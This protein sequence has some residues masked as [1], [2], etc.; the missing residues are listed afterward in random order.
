MQRGF[1]RELLVERDVFAYARGYSG[2]S[3]VAVIN[4]GPER[5]IALR[6]V[7]LPD[8]EYL[9]VLGVLS[10]PVRVVKGAI[11]R[12]RVPACSA[13]LLEHSLPMPAG[14]SLVV[15]RLNGYT[16]RYDDRVVVVGDAPELGAWNPEK[17]TRLQYVNGNLWMGDLCFEASAGSDVLYRYVVFDRA[18]QVH[19]EDRTPRLRHVGASGVVEWRDRWET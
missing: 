17:G 15:A 4:R 19:Y 3:L 12:L 7:L 8:G 11:E 16:S 10:E 5:T 18:G 2:T 13:V 6:D 14:R 9:D 1:T